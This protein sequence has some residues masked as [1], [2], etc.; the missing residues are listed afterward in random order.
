MRSFLELFKANLKIIYRNRSAV[1][2]TILLPAAI[3]VGLSVLPIKS[4]FPTNLNYSDYV[5]PGIVAMA[6]MQG[7]IYGLAYW[8]VEMKARGVIKRFL[9]TPIKTSELVLSLLASRIIVIFTQVIVLTTL[10]LLI[11][12]AR[13]AG[14]FVSI[15]ILCLL[16]GSIFLLIGL[17]IS[18]FSNSYE[19]VAP[20]T[21]AIGLP[22]T[23]LGNIFYP[24]DILPRTLQ[25]VAKLLPITYLAD[26][27]RMSYLY[28]LDF[29]HI[30]KDVLILF[31]WLIIILTVTLKIFKL[32]E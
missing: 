8:L 31:I 15:I 18:N 32:N 22:L 2:W 29:S 17:L 13:F 6:I 7:G 1:F 28:P 25:A 14:N 12:H 23:F 10:G 30:A 16:G 9:A 19:T 21:S 20:I 4:A 24:V 26:G 5:L 3:Y 11:F 27:L